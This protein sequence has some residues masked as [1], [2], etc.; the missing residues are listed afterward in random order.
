MNN[1]THNM[2]KQTNKFFASILLTTV[3]CSSDM[4][5]GNGNGNNGNGNGNQTYYGNGHAYGHDKQSRKPDVPLDGGLSFLAAAGA[6][7]G[8][9]KYKENKAKKLEK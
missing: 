6:G 5:A 4:Y 3:L 2:K 9:K 8:I 1:K 7:L